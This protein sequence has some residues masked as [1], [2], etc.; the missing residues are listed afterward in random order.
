[1]PL[2]GVKIVSTCD[3]VTRA[4]LSHAE[5]KFTPREGYKNN[6]LHDKSSY[7]S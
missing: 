5:S 7:C 2:S 4:T 6:N 1:M 3:T